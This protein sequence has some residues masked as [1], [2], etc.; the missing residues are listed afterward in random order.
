MPLIFATD[1]FTFL[2]IS[3]QVAIVLQVF[4]NGCRGSDCH[5]FNSISK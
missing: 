4:L 3:E 5:M 2:V 1:C